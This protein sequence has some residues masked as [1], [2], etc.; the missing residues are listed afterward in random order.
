MYICLSICIHPLMELPATNTFKI[1]TSSKK[2]ISLLVKH[3][4]KCFK[5]LIIEKILPAKMPNHW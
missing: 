2:N 5:K 1:L 4:F 3:C